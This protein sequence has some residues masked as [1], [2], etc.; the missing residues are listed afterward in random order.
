M[1]EFMVIAAPRSGTT[2]AA[3][4]LTTDTTLCLHDPLWHRQ[5]FEL[6]SI[7]SKK[8]LGI[9]CTAIA[10]LPEYVNKHP[11]RKVIL[12][13]NLDEVNQSLIAIGSPALTKIWEGA[14]EQIIGRHCDW[15]EIFDSPKDIYE[16]LLG[17]PFDEERHAELS[18][19]E[20]Q[21][22]FDGLT[23]NRTAV[24]GLFNQLRGIS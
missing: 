3:N 2:W 10:L 22:D 24:S 23:I 1:I 17:L 4:W 6:D 9:S 14:L 7:Q 12:H 16:Y 18:K 13:R 20:M 21:P 15:R 8:M 5:Y 11:A 19:I